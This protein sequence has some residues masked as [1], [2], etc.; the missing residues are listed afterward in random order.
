M[1]FPSRSPLE[2]VRL[3]Q[4]RILSKDSANEREISSLLEYFSQRVLPILAAGKDS[5]R[6]KASEEAKNKLEYNPLKRHERIQY[7]LTPHR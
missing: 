2:L 1:I 4:S 5:A 6:F 3:I 7:P